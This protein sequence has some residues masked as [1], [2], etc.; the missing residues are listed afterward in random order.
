[1]EQ[2]PAREWGARPGR[3]LTGARR[4]PCRLLVIPGLVTVFLLAVFVSA[5]LAAGSVWLN[6]V[7][8]SANGHQFG[9]S[10]DLYQVAAQPYAYDYACANAYNGSTGTRYFG[11]YYCGI[12]SKAAYTPQFNANYEPEDWNS[13]SNADYDWSWEWYS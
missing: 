10:H 8:T 9:T 3:R 11:V 1:M 4:Q 12:P 6:W 13:S 7:E 2:I 5:S